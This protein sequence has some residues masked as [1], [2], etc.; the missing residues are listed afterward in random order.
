MSCS[1][2]N[3]VCESKIQQFRPKFWRDKSVGFTPIHANVKN[4]HSFYYFQTS[5]WIKYI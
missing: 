4:T 3:T 1:S 2:D 5:L